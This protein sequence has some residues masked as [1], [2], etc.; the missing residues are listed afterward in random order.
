MSQPSFTTD[1]LLTLGEQLE[2][3]NFTQI[4]LAMREL[5]GDEDAAKLRRTMESKFGL[6]SIEELVKEKFSA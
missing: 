3:P 2:R 4:D 1:Q 5:H 6:K